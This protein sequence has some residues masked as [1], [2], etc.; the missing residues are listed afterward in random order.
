MNSEKVVKIEKTAENRI[1]VEFEG[2]AK[3]VWDLMTLCGDLR[4]CW[5]YL[6]TIFDREGRIADTQI[7]PYCAAHRNCCECYADQ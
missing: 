6:V 1:V 4:T 3:A 7:I 5:V 2:G